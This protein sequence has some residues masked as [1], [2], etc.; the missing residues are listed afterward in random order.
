[1]LKILPLLRQQQPFPTAYYPCTSICLTIDNDS[2]EQ[3]HEIIDSIQHWTPCMTKLY[4]KFADFNHSNHL[5]FPFFCTE[6]IQAVHNNLHLQWVELDVRNVKYDDGEEDIANNALEQCHAWL[7]QYCEWNQKLH[8]ALDKADSILLNLWPYV[9]YLA[10]RGGA[11]MLYWH[12]RNNPKYILKD[13]HSCPPPALQMQ[14]TSTGCQSH[15]ST[16][17]KWKRK[18]T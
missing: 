10:N 17:A 2:L 13:W 14:E 7:E 3:C 4:L 1:M 18:C 15:D 8:L 16:A 6:L 9:Y 12:W 5:F 11:N